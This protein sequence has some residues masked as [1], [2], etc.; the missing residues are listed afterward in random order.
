MATITASPTG[1]NWNATAAWVGGVVPGAGDDVLLTATSGNMTIN[2]A[3]SVL[4]LDCTG[5]TGTLTHAAAVTFTVAGLKLL[6][7]AGMTYTLGSATTSAITFTSTAGTCLITS[8]GKTL[9]NQTYNGVG[10]TW[11]L[12]DPQTVGAT[13]TVTRTAGSVTTNGQ[14]CSWGNYS[15]ITTA[16]GVLSLGASLL[17]LTGGAAAWAVSTSPA[18]TFSCGTSTITMAGT[19]CRFQM[20]SSWV[21]NNLVFTGTNTSFVTSFGPYN[22]SAANI[23]VTGNAIKTESWIAGA[24]TSLGQ[25]NTITVTGTLRITGQSAT[26]RILVQSGAGNGTNLGH[27]VTI[28]CANAPVLSNVDFM[29][30]TASG[31]AAP[32]TGTSLGDARGNSGITFTPAVTQAWAGNTTGNWSTAANWTSRVPLPQDNVTISALTSGTVT[33]DMPRIGGN[34]DLTGSTGGTLA[35]GTNLTSYGSMTLVAGVAFAGTATAWTFAGRATQTITSAGKSFSTTVISAP[36]GS[37]TLVDAFTATNAALTVSAGT[38]NDG[39]QNVTAATINL[40]GI[41]GVPRAVVGGS[42]TWTCTSTGVVWSVISTL[43]TFTAPALISLTNATAAAFSFTGGGVAYNAVSITGGGTGVFT[44]VG[45]S[46]FTTLTINAP[47]SVVFTAGT[48]QVVTSFVATGS[49]GNVITLTS[50]VGGTAWTISSASGTVSCDWL[51]LKDS[52]ATGGAGFYAGHNST[53]V[54]GNTGWNFFA[55]PVLGAGADSFP[56]SDGVMRGVALARSAAETVGVSDTAT[57]VRSSARTGAEA[58]VVSD[59]A[60]GV[61]ALVRSASESVAVNDAAVRGGVAARVGSEAVTVADAAARAAVYG[62]GGAESVGCSDSV[63][64]AG[65]AARAASETVVLG[66]AAARSAAVGAAA[67]DAVVV[68]DAAAGRLAVGRSGAEVVAVVDAVLSSGVV[69]TS[70]AA[71]VVV[72]SDSVGRVSA[73]RVQAVD[74]VSVADV[75]G[76]GFGVL[77]GVG[78]LVGVGDAA[79]GRVSRSRSAADVVACGDGAG[80]RVTV[81]RSMVESVVVGDAAH[82]VVLR[83]AVADPDHLSAVL[84]TAPVVGVDSLLDEVTAWTF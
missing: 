3:S 65:S 33:I 24:G 47:K 84:S 34:V 4:S 14:T 27:P 17:T 36:G 64:R 48:T 10:G 54:S 26:N 67:A 19:G 69:L 71:D 60:G 62:R 42:G 83:I 55:P 32:F 53:N 11:Q 70:S 29:D 25:T 76:R 18:S 13:A 38:F 7:V 15:S 8:G 51:S 72:V 61:R 40:N 37:Y 79:S 41:S 30:V 46:S 73:V 81:T 49:T 20:G 12:Q 77:R 68:A 50:S 82:A 2:V 16:N 58:V 43:L 52:T 28:S 56:V 35:R 63:A 80:G 44:I 5:Y 23:T 66:D 75:A 1:G 6:L 59:A 22:C 57:R 9:G 31:T 78:E 21:Y 39:N 74:V 45:S